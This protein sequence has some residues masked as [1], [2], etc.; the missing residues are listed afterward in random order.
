MPHERIVAYTGTLHNT[1]KGS[2]NII[3]DNIHNAYT[4]SY[5]TPRPQ[6]QRQLDTILLTLIL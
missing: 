3:M 1:S 6:R 5:K 2:L 4:V